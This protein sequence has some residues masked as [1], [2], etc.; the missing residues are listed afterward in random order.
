MT[1][2]GIKI[3]VK[4]FS[5]YRMKEE[6]FKKEGVKKEESQIEIYKINKYDK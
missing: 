6:T 3:N 4:G 2:K 5:V 1:D